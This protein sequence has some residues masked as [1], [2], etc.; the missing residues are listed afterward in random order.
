MPPYYDLKH[1]LS[2]SKS[3]TDTRKITGMHS[4]PVMTLRENVVRLMAHHKIKTQTDLA[5]RSGVNQTTIQRLLKAPVPPSPAL[6]TIE[7][8]ATALRVAP[9]QLLMPGLPIGSPSVAVVRGGLSHQALTVCAALQRLPDGAKR[10]LL[11][12]AS[13][14][15]SQNS[16]SDTAALTELK[17]LAATP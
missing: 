3:I 2:M 12:F 1:I 14:L 4:N 13:Y 9:W 6:E 8:L 16:E 11:S 17:E 15:S 5:E 10:E 7:G